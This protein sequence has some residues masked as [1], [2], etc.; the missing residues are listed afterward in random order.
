MGPGCIVCL[1]TETSAGSGHR[2]F[3]DLGGRACAPFGQLRVL[4]SFHLNTVGP[5]ST[6]RGTAGTRLFKSD[7]MISC[8]MQLPRLYALL[9]EDSIPNVWFGRDMSD[10]VCLVIRGMD[11]GPVYCR[12]NV[13]LFASDAL[14]IRMDNPVVLRVVVH[15][16]SGRIRIMLHVPCHFVHLNSLMYHIT[17]PGGTRKTTYVGYGAPSIFH[18]NHNNILYIH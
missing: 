8:I 7:D 9:P 5:S 3:F 4:L 13:G 2:Q 18:C 12:W 10:Q 6:L 15:A 1:H 17:F 16:L 14:Q 11:M